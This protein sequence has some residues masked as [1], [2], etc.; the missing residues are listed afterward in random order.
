MEEQVRVLI[1]GSGPAGYTAAIYA[2]RANLKPVLYEGIEP[3]GQLTTTT[4]VENFPGHPDSVSGPDLMGLM[5]RQAERFGAD[6]RTG[7]VTR[8]DLSSRPFHVV[9]DGE[10]EIKAETLIIATGAT[11]KYL[12]LPSETKFRGQGV[13]ACATCDGFFYRKKDVA[14]VGGGDTA[15]EEAT[16]LASL[17]RKVYLI[18]RKPHL[19]ASKAMKKLLLLLAAECCIASCAEIRSTSIGKAYPTT[20]TAPELYFDWKDVPSDYET[21]GSIKATPFGK[22]LEEAQA[23]IEQIGREKGAD[24]IVFEGVVSETSAPTYTTTEKIEKNDDGS[25][26]R[27]AT[28]SQSVFT[29][30]RLLATFIKYKTQTN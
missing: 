18:V 22:T 2:S 11:A 30:N 17:C 25:K 26:T 12:G 9:I 23:L 4:D 29:T 16:Y 5:R 28:T 21:M 20:G 24:A 10:K 6:I 8:A 14:V 7:N 27:T 13:S 15:C 1:I 3:G 19:R